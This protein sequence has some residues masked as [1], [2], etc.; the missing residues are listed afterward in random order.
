[1]TS[2][3]CALRRTTLRALFLKAPLRAELTTLALEVVRVADAAGISL[4]A[5]CGIPGT[6]GR[7][8]ARGDAAA[9]ADVESGLLRYG[10]KVDPGA[11]SG[12]AQDL[13]RG[14]R[15]E[16]SLIN[17]AVVAEA[18]RRGLAAPANAALIAALDGA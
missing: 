11:T 2:P 13:A 17:G 12:M 7:G 8:A 9:L 5:I 10:A 3:L 16:V 1:M 14:R 4:D 15:T 18:A 6:T